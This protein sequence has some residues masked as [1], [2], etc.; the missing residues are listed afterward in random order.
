MKNSQYIN[1]VNISI[2]EMVRLTCNEEQ[3]NGEKVN[4]I[5]LSMH[6]EFLKELGRVINKALDDY[7]ALNVDAGK[8][9]N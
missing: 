2:N 5:V 9:M 8:G 4:V 3:H 7:K 6:V 1:Q